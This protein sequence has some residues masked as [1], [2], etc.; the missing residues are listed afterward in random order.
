MKSSS[1]VKSKMQK[2]LPIHPSCITWN[3]IMSRNTNLERNSLTAKSEQQPFMQKWT[4]PIRCRLFISRQK[5]WPIMKWPSLAKISRSFRESK[6]EQ[7][8]R[9]H[10][11]TVIPSKALS[12]PLRLKSKAFRA[13]W[14]ILCWQRDIREMTALVRVMSNHNMK[15]SWREPKKSSTLK[16]EITK[17]SKRSSNTAAKPVTTSNWRLTPI[18]K[19]RFKRSWTIASNRLSEAILIL[20]AV[21]P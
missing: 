16:P 19:T 6:S 21:M 17:L 5:T 7:A 11:L 10:I 13:I 18:F 20:L 4:V 2:K 8:G 12:E 3:R 14:S 15:T 9:V 1:K